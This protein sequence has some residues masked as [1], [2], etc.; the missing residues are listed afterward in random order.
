MLFSGNEFNDKDAEAIADGIRQTK[1]LRSLNLCQNAIQD[2]GGEAI[3]DAMG[4][5]IHN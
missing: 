4:E 2:R 5:G 1:T 3:A